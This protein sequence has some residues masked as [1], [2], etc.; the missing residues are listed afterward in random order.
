MA[1]ENKKLSQNPKKESK[2]IAE[3]VQLRLQPIG[4]KICKHVQ[5]N[6]LSPKEA[7]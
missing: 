3:K 7:R 6:K 5:T 4:Q 2:T 1:K